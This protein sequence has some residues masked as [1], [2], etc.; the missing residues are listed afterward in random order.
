MSERY[1]GTDTKTYAGS[2]G[3]HAVELEFDKK[4]LVLNRARLRV[5]GDEV[6]KAN[7]FYGEKSL[8]AEVD[9]GSTIEVVIDSGGAGELTRAQLKQPDGSWVDLEESVGA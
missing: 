8:K 5:D 1:Y 3:G 4:L 9:G 2:S 6:D 7:V